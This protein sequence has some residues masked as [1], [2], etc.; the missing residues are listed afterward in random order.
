M[1]CVHREEAQNLAHTQ[2]HRHSFIVM[3]RLCY[4]HTLMAANI[5]DHLTSKTTTTTTTIRNN[6]N[7]RFDA[8]SVIDEIAQ[9]GHTVAIAARLCMHNAHR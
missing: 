1:L 6:S 5:K 8:H 9:L 2:T 3:H 4:T 7:D